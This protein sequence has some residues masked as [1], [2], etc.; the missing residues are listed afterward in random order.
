MANKKK[1]LDENGLSHLL[2][3][4]KADIAEK[5]DSTHTHNYAGSS[6]S[7]GPANSAVKLNTDAGS[8]TQPVYFS[9]G[10]PVATTYTL[11]KSVPSDAKF[12][13]TTY[14]AAGTALGLVK[15][16]GDVTI[17]DGVITVSDDSHNHTIE[18][19]DGLQAALNNK[20]DSSALTAHTGDTD[21]P[22]NVT[23]AQIGAATT[24]ALSSHTS[25]VSNP[26]K[27][28]AA[29]VGLGNV[30]NT[31]DADKPVSTVQAT[32]I[33]DAKK[34][35]TDAQST[36]NTHAARTDNPHSVTKAQ[37]GLSN[38]NNTAD[39]A[40]PV[41]TAQATAIATA[42]SE[43]ITEANGY[44]DE[45]I[46]LL[47]NN[48]SEAV[49][50]IMELNTAMEENE[51][52]VAALEQAIGTKANK[53]EIPTGFTITAEAADDDIVVLAGESGTNKVK[54][55]ATH[56]KKGPSS[57]YTSGNTTT[58]ISGSAGSGTIKIPQITVDT[59]GHVTAAADESVTITLP[60][61]PSVVDNLTS[62]SVTSP[63][64]AAQG[65][66]L[67]DKITAINT[68]MENLGAGDMLK[69]V[70][71]TDG[72]GIVETADKLNANAGSATN[73]VYF[74]NGVPVKTTYTL[75][76][77]VPSDAVFTDT[78]YT[79]GIT[80]GASGTTTNAAVTNPY[81]KV[82]DN[83]THRSQIQIKG[84]GATTVSS[85]ENGVITISS[86]DNNTVYTHPAATAYNSGLYKVTV[87][88]TGHVTAATAVTK[89]DITALG[90]PGS[91]TNTD[92][93]VTS[94]GNH[95]TPTADTS[96]AL[97]VDASSTTAAT[98]GSTDLVTGVN[99]QRDAKG[100][101]TGVTVDSIQMP[102][103][104]N[105]DTKNTTG[106]TDTSSKIFLVGA[107][108]QAANP[109]TYS[110]DTVYVG[111]DGHLYSNG[112]KVAPHRAG[113]Y[114]LSEAGSTTAGTWT[115]TSSDITSLYD[116]MAIN[117]EIGVAG[118]S[119]T[120]LNIN[121]LGAK[122][123]YLRGTSKLTTQYAV[124]TIINLI[125]SSANDCW[126][127]ADYD[128]NTRNSVGDY[129]KNNTKLYFVGTTST[130]SATSSSYATSY[131]NS[132]CYVGTDNCLYSNGSKTITAADLDVSALLA[133]IAALEAKVGFSTDEDDM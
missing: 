102:A 123:V 17:T 43:A 72:D 50:S 98:W 86:T 53:S 24:S 77:S 89:A 73:P 95:Y 15:S 71:D 26:H 79:T 16:G 105:S 56:A 133:R 68:N 101:V 9:G 52:V 54:Y 8:A 25:D 84:S 11:G 30:N 93:K 128:A 7:G 6:T 75:G 87:N 3:K 57:A 32:A 37:V 91:D 125:Y 126:Y 70:Y 2:T 88:D 47:M 51:E 131:T 109:V 67:N 113:V 58:S 96:A 111:T 119:T 76:K 20:A 65:K 14:G 59:Y 74:A 60:T 33:A 35:G 46:G 127:K 124:G 23:A 97:S 64:S 107:T 103:N 81:V 99:I 83:S 18:N 31:S 27:V 106:S 82:K 12:T 120:T 41:S 112:E 22:H 61:V 21:N 121:G 94:V 66:A 19:V 55:T 118:A 108:S 69:S 122:T 4:I 34:A 110:H 90:I 63:L 42:K 38:V 78:H 13:D 48:S 100:H 130:D 44:T 36:I 116:G 104:P 10:K 49:D 129:Q 28:T 40:K 117:F 92:T 114:F 132:K 29:Q 39:S 115:A 85:D 62:T 80:A 1:Y 5:S 45:K